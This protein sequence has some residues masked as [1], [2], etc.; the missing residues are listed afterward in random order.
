M[1]YRL[2]RT[3]Y[4]KTLTDEGCFTGYASVFDVI[5]KMHDVVIKGAFK[6]TIKQWKKKAHRLPM[7]WQHDIK[8]PIGYYKTIEEDDKGLFVEGQF[9]K[10]EDALAQK[11]YTHV[12]AGTVSGLSIGYIPDDCKYDGDKDVFILKKIDLLEISLVTIPA[13]DDARVDM[14]KTIGHHL[15]GPKYF[16]HLL[17]QH[18]LSKDQAIQFIKNGY[19]N[20]NHLDKNDYRQ[21]LIELIDSLKSD[22]F[23]NGVN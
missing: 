20:S 4:I 9:L 2:D 11:A 22:H 16:E 14:I 3:F 18:G 10:D 12:K 5:D 6:E 15:P 1:Q 7:L 19:N 23:F 21:S 17:T 13:N 8:E